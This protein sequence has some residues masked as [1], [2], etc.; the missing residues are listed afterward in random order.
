MAF[1]LPLMPS[2]PLEMRVSFPLVLYAQKTAQCLALQCWLSLHCLHEQQGSHDPWVVGYKW[3]HRFSD[4]PTSDPPTTLCSFSILAWISHHEWI[5]K[6]FLR[7]HFQKLS[8]KIKL[9]LYDSIK[10]LCNKWVVQKIISPRAASNFLLKPK[11]RPHLGFS[12]CV[13]KLT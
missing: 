1:S 9:N 6:S 2:R 13:N 3:G 5:L 11:K 10:S 12:G 8:T 7:G 4:S